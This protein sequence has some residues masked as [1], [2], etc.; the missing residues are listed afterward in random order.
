MPVLPTT[1]T[2]VRSA[3]DPREVTKIALRLKHQV[4][5]VVPCQLE[6]S[7]I[8]K[9]HSPIITPSVIQTAKEAG[10][11]ENKACVVFCLLVCKKWFSKQA[12]LELWDADMHE[13]RAL[14]CEVIAKQMCVSHI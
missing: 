4:E 11:E 7:A 13:V 3:V 6:E 9:A 10:G 5:T 2:E 14:A 12:V 1:R 8:T